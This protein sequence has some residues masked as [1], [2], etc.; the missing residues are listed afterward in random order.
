MWSNN[1]IGIP[2]KEKGRDRSGT[3]CWGLVRLIYKEQYNIDLPSFANEYPTVDDRERIHELIAQYK[4]AWNPVETPS[5][6]S[7]VLFRMLGSET[8]IGVAI[9]EQEFIHVREGA[10]SVIERFDSVNWKN[11]LIG[12]FRYTT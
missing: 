4:E 3:D 9:N 7:V 1:Y 12:H 10:D 11:R 5:E 8:H 2:F 6:G